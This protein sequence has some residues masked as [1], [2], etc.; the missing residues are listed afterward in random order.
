MYF[1]GL[2]IGSFTLPRLGDLYG[3]KQVVLLGKVLHIITCLVIL[4]SKSFELTLAMN[5]LIGLA[6]AANFVCFAFLSENVHVSD[7]PWLTSVIFIGESSSL[8]WAGLWFKFVS[9]DWHFF[10]GFPLIL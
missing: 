5:F 8:V 10:Y 2:V 4:F 3:R 1:A 6:L 7:I 9:K